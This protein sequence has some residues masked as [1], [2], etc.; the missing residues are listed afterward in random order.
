M[1]TFEHPDDPD[2]NIVYIGDYV[3][4]A[5]H[6]VF[7]GGFWDADSIRVLDLKKSKEYALKHYEEHIAKN[8]NKDYFAV[9]AIPSHDPEGSDETG[10]RLLAKRLAARLGIGDGRQF[11]RRTKLV[12]KLANGGSR[13]L[14]VH[15]DSIKAQH[16]DQF[17]G[18][19]LLLLDDVLTSGNS[20]LAC[21]KILLKAGAAEVVCLALGKTK[22]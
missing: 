5:W 14:T 6:K 16:V 1:A 20:M 3:P 12:D 22:H 4:W 10:I 21:R 7:I 19:R 8:V 9:C 18:K 13:A 15:L 17:A 11:L 2:A